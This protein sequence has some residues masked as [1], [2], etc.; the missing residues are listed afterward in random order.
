MTDLL[1]VVVNDPFQASLIAPL[2][3]S[4]ED[5][6]LASP[7]SKFPFCIDEWE[8]SFAKDPENSSLLFKIEGKIIGHIALLPKAEDLYLCYVIL[9]PEYRGKNIA[10]KM[11]KEAEEFC[12]LNYPNLE[13]F[14]NVSR[15]NARAKK[16]YEKMGYVTYQELEEK[17]KMVK[18]LK[19]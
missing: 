2:Y 4:Q 1:E 11:I 17:F 13:L 3:A 15:E 18:R 14:L 6:K 10:E 7:L 12:R 19:G 16:L 8:E 5:L 9:S